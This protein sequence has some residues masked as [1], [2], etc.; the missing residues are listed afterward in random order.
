MKIVPAL[1]SL[2]LPWPLKRIFLEKTCGFNLDKTSRIGF[3]IV[4]PVN[5]KMAP[6]SRIG[7]G[8]VI[9]HAEE[10]ICG[11]HSIIDRSNWITGHE[12][13]GAHFKRFGRRSALILGA[14]AAITR[15][16]IIDCTDLVEIGDFTTIAGFRSQII[17][18]GIN[19]ET[20]KQDCSPIR[21]G[22]YCLVGT[23]SILL[24][25]SSLPDYS[26]LAAGGVLN[27][28]HTDELFVYGG[29]PAIPKKKLSDS[30][31]YFHRERGIV[32]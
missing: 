23:S 12:A 27:K 6:H 13:S 9:V 22:K 29:V 11:S 2:L 8:N 32:D 3:S 14:H 28:H 5:L 26:V 15:S 31:L 16:H 24:G 19:V 4:C 10:V 17:T 25:G 21:V 30:S 7:H 20:S 1:I 18:H